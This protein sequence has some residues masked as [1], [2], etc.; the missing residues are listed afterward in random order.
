MIALYFLI[1]SVLAHTVYDAFYIKKDFE[2]IVYLA[3]V[4]VI[5]MLL[6]ILYF[7]GPSVF[8]PLYGLAHGMLIHDTSVGTFIINKNEK[9]SMDEKC[10]LHGIVN[11][12]RYCIIGYCVH[13]LLCSDYVENFEQKFINLLISNFVI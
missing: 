6:P 3:F 4:V 8:I 12:V 13:I 9:L 11:F 5:I 1:F 2:Q 10:L 7:L